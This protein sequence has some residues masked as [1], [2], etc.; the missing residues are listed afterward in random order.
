[1]TNTEHIVDEATF[2]P[3]GDDLET[4]DPLRYP[5]Y[6]ALVA[7]L[8]RQGVS[9]SVV[10]GP[11]RI[12]GLDV[13]VALFDFRFLAGSLGEVA[14]ERVARAAERAAKRATPLVLHTAT[15]GARMQEGMRA[16]VQMPKLAVAR[17]TLQEAHQPLVAVLGNPTTG[18]VLAS[19]AGLAD[20][21][22][23]E[24]GA[25]LGFAGPRVVQRFTGRALE[26][27][28][29][30]ADAAL[31][32]GL[33]DGVVS[34]SG[35]RSY[36]ARAL[37]VLRPDDP[38]AGE[39]PPAP[40]G[41]P[42]GDPWDALRRARIPERPTGAGLIAL[43][44]PGAVALRG[45]R[46]GSDDA[47]VRAAIGRVR[48]R[49]ALLLALDRNH[50]PGPGAYRK[51]LRC[52][53]VA[54]RLQLPVVTF[55]DTSGADPSEASESAG[56]AA[57]IARLLTRMLTVAVPTLSLVTGE[58]GS[59]GALAF[60]AADRLVALQGAIFSVISPELAAEILWRDPGR[61][62][63]AAR[64]LHIGARALVDLGIADEVAGGAPTAE[65]LAGIV[66]YHL[67]R[68]ARHAGRDELVARRR[69]RWRGH[70][71]F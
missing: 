25:T 26:S 40:P 23:A 19:I 62:P 64:L 39:R 6:P 10:S 58:G 13:E 70:G 45:D 24:R 52:L 68:L 47:A 37:S 49:R 5:S 48:G 54:E 27:G 42:E 32:H 4:S 57:A 2:R 67:G 55:I 38:V 22:V 29:H 28:S 20:I 66:A 69:L 31:R 46:A 3:V 17:L 41:E 43:V 30:T 36:L 61:A 33:V 15:G 12:S 60:A 8:R 34:P 65:V 11:A 63:E 21:T 50:N 71:V 53:D 9:E 51:A 44:S 14:G 18:A 16:L 59:G 35:V 56:I 1:L 7:R